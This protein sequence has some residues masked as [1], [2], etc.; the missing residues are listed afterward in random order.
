M[1]IVARMPRRFAAILLAT[2][3]LATL[4]GCSPAQSPGPPG[5]AGPSASQGA[6]ETAA[7]CV[8]EAIPD[9][10][11]DPQPVWAGR[12]WYEVFVRSY[13]DSDGDGIG[14]L[15]GLTAKLDYIKGLGIGGIW[16]MPVA[17]AVSYHGYDVT[18]YT[19]VER[20]YGDAA[21]LRA[22]VAAAHER[23]IL[24]IV[25]FVINHTSRDHP[26]F[27][28]ALQGGPHRDWYIWSET[29]PGWPPVAG[30]NP[31]HRTDAGDYYY[32]AFWEGMPDL[33][34]RNPDVTA[35]IK[36]VAGTWLDDFG[37]DGFRIDA[38]RHLI[39]DDGAHQSNTPETYA[40]LEDFTAS[41]H[42]A[43]PD[44][45]LLGEAYDTSKSAGAYVP[46]SLDST[47]DFGLAA[48]M[49][50]A[51]ANRRTPPI[52]TAVAETI[53]SWP[54]NRESSF[55]TNHDQVRVMSQVFGNVPSAH[56]AA[57]MLL[58]GPG[59]PFVYYGE[60]IGM[61]GRKPDELIRTPMQWSADGPAGGFS[62]ATPW[63]PLSEDW[64]T[65]N[66]AAQDGDPASLLAAYRDGIAFRAEH[67]AL[68]EGGT[69]LVEG[70]S[71]TVV[72]W[73]RATAGETLL[74]VVNVGAEPVSDYALSLPA[75]P[76]CDLAGVELLRAIGD[77]APGEASAPVVNA[78]GGF[79]AW[80]PLGTLEPR[81]GYVIRLGGAG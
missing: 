9:S 37:V 26:W 72:G 43:H 31:W 66:V 28:D 16:L 60:E 46:K 24:V 65:V 42:A 8:P 17:E 35:E 41:I 23:D 38:A 21:A 13:S 68:V 33:N 78:T 58:T 81:S 59:L 36:R 20:D 51:V 62:G 49:V 61:Q 74:V 18:E 50:S 29:D 56:L 39:E 75:G 2:C 10:A 44:A 40:W 34:L 30:P 22:F 71:P 53:D 64:Q 3:L 4:A 19:A 70:G 52:R 67:P 54:V 12:T 77:P 14:D 47:F 11:A 32:G 76:L 57:F 69:R 63:E 7:T 45:L 27:V 79:D 73:L 5:T 25:D 1:G 15:A 6:V 55:L 80:Q 48:A